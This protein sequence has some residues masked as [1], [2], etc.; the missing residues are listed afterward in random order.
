ME[1]NL[2]FDEQEWIFCVVCVC[3]LLV[4]EQGQRIIACNATVV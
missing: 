4:E 1:R 3:I 2:F